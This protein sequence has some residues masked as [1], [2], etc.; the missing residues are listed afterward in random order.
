MAATRTTE[1][2]TRSSDAELVSQKNVALLIERMR[3]VMAHVPPSNPNWP[4]VVEL[5]EEAAKTS[6][7]LEA[8][9]SEPFEAKVAL[10]ANHLEGV[11]NINRD[12]ALTLA[13]LAL[14]SA[15]VKGSEP[16]RPMRDGR[17]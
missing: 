11:H 8:A 17:D 10:A 12:L 16:N 14:R 13:R 9:A 4:E 2:R 3:A 5:N 15:G 7:D 6:R 1:V